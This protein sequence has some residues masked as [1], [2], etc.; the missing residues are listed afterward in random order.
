M[1]GLRRFSRFSAM[2]GAVAM[3]AIASGAEFHSVLDDT[4]NKGSGTIDLMKNITGEQLASYTFVNGGQMYFGVDLNENASGN[5]YSTSIGV[6]L[7]SLTLTVTTTDG[8]FTF[9]D[10]YTNTTASILE[11]GATSA[12][13]Y[14]TLFGTTGANDL[15]GSLSASDLSSFDDVVSLNNVFFTGN[16]LS[17]N[18]SV[19]FLNTANAGEN[20][21]FFDFSGGFEKFAILSGTDA[22]AI[23]VAASGTED[24]PATITYEASTVL[25]APQEDAPA[26]GGG[27]EAP[28]NAPAAPEPAWL[29]MAAAVALYARAR[30]SGSRTRSAA[31]PSGDGLRDRS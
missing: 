1:N 13:T 29:V 17:A 10:Y 15:G 5:E 7:K 24:A 21:A 19:Q 2:A 28:A 3:L 20:E 6:A 14:Y 4:I 31:A 22:T 25:A 27:G 8:V 18:L 30:Y 16:V 12:A 26:T 9:S 11:Q 23:E